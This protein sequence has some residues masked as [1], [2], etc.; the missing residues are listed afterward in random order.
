MSTHTA[1]LHCSQETHPHSPPNPQLLLTAWN[2]KQSEPSWWTGSLKSSAKVLFIPL[3][4]HLKLSQCDPAALNPSVFTRVI[5]R[6]NLLDINAALTHQ[7]QDRQSSVDWLLFSP[8][9]RTSESTCSKKTFNTHLDPSDSGG[10]S[11]MRTG[12]SRSHSAAGTG[13]A[14]W[15]RHGD[16]CGGRAQSR[17]APSHLSPARSHRRPRWSPGGKERWKTKE[18]HW[19]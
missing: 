10:R 1:S 9:S 8:P 5:T 19:R 12:W 7:K 2:Q 3:L 4:W 17:S 15:R 11:Q 16:G 18:T 14:T 13:K 6:L